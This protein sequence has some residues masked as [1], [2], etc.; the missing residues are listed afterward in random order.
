MAKQ[1]FVTRQAQLDRL[2]AFLC[3]A[4]G[5]HG[6]V[7][8]VI[9]EAG[10]GKT[11]L[12]TEFAARAGEVHSGLV[13]AIGNCNAQTGTGDPYLPFREILAQLTGDVEA[14]LAQ[15]AIS[16]EN[17]Y[18]LQ[19]LVRS[20][21]DAL[22]R[23]GPDLINVL[24][25]GSALVAKLGAYV[26]D[27]AGWL[28]KLQ[29]LVETKAT[30]PAG[31]ALEQSHIFEQYT[32]VLKALAGQRP[33]V[34]VLDNL[35]WA[36]SASVSL[37]FHLGQ[38]IGE[39][40]ILILG[41]YRGEDVK[42][43]RGGE[44]HPLEKALNE[45]KRCFGDVWVDLD[46]AE[47]DEARPFVDALLDLEPSRL[48]QGFRQALVQHTG[49]HPLFT[50]ELLRNMREHGDLVRDADGRW[51]EG[52]SLD[53]D[54]LPP[55]VEGVIEERIG[56]LEAELQESLTVGSVEGREFT[57]EVIARVRAIDERRLV[58]RLGNELD[59]QHHLV[60]SHGIRR[61]GLQPLS[62]YRF[63]HSLFQKYLYNS[64]DAAQKSYLHEDVG[65]ALEELYGDQTAEIAIQLARHFEEAGLAE[66]A[67]HYLLL[68]GQGAMRVSA[69][70]EA[71][72]H[73]TK[74]LNLLQTLPAT[75]ERDQMEL[76]LQMALA[77]TTIITRGWA[78]PDVAA[79]LDR[80][81]E[82]CRS[83]GN[84]PQLIPVLRGLYN[85]YHSHAE[86]RV[87]YELAEQL[88]TLAQKAQD[89]ASQLM[90]YQ[91][92]GQSQ[93]E[94]GDFATGRDTL[95]RA[96]T[97]HDPEQYRSLAYLYGDEDGVSCRL[98][99]MLGLFALGYPDQALARAREA[100][101]MA[102]ALAHPHVLAYTLYG[103]S[104]AYLFVRDSQGAI[105]VAERALA[106]CCEQG[107][108]FWQKAT[109][110][111]HGYALAMQG[112]VIQGIAEVSHGLSAYRSIGARVLQTSYLAQLA[113]MHL[114][115]GHVDAGLAIVGQG[116]AA[117]NETSERC[118]EAVLYR[119]R[120]ELLHM[121]GHEVEAEADLH[122]ALA[123]A[124]AQQARSWELRATLNLCR[125]WCVQGK[126]DEARRML[127]DIYGWFSEGFDTPD[128][129][130]AKALLVD[131]TENCASC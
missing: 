119:L 125:L 67:I 13:V 2:D 30:L 98:N 78:A 72:G 131:L 83:A 87:A 113:E 90:A 27:Q 91:A 59:R 115:A 124:R 58:R 51:V 55:R 122:K 117:V 79:A 80:E 3:Q 12:V 6:Q 114:M 85:H 63:R 106:L 86:H 71:I 56:R 47:K 26:V 126:R 44:R 54:V 104:T 118:S 111:N 129:Q 19:V 107:I 18:R 36:D 49:G 84:M 62:A 1:R 95:E 73:L 81:R 130:E 21:C 97:F 40:R 33:L 64:L 14:K 24:V 76:P 100:L 92:L 23:F 50:I 35:H 16:S 89:P 9:G 38:R 15:G 45:F 32:N 70:T 7:A 5:Q 102:E 68:A 22:I 65:N 105:A 109:M 101:E 96:L 60:V 41:T 127:A 52:T 48:G 103:L 8:F 17:A 34:L 11:A 94:M 74:A 46:Q 110:I 88:T 121:Q 61:L 123:V 120:A 28:D 66:K 25:P 10:A 108:S 4:L 57:A 116:L 69:N 75:A 39:S 77:T 112:H 43:G 82:L 37:L 99:L 31:V 53:W 93:I 128:L 29:R 20:S 42:L